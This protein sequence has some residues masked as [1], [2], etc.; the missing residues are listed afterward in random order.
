MPVGW[1]ACDDKAL[2]VG[3]ARRPIGP[4]GPRWVGKNLGNLA[5]LRNAFQALG[6]VIG[7]QDL[8][9]LC[10]GPLHFIGAR[11]RPLQRRHGACKPGA[12][13][14]TALQ[15]PTC[16]LQRGAV[17]SGKGPR[18]PPTTTW[19][20]HLMRISLSPP[21]HHQQLAHGRRN[22]CAGH[23]SDEG[24]NSSR[25]GRRGGLGLSVW[26][27]DWRGCER[28]RSETRGLVSRTTL[29]LTLCAGK[30]L[31]SAAQ[32]QAAAVR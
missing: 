21:A 23:T 2:G 1:G 8:G 16:N 5:T 14:R 9:L 27:S 31:H 17:V 25:T 13:G 29:F 20:N 19:T 4:L 22:T 10:R 6:G 32:Q 3:C 18:R 15:P 12:Q 30:S 28:K 24:G 11:P 7:A 26:R